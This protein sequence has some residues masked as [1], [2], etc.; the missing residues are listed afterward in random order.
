MHVRERDG[1]PTAS[2]WLTVAL[3]D[4]ERLVGGDGVGCVVSILSC[5]AAWVVGGRW[6]GVS[7]CGVSGD[8]R[9]G[10]GSLP[11]EGDKVVPQCGEGVRWDRVAWCVGG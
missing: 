1:C 9:S 4:V 3:V 11:H 6:C 2:A 5:A 7:V 10:V 8:D